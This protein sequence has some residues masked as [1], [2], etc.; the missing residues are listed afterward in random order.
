M[1]VGEFCDAIGVSNRSLNTFLGQSGKYKGSGSN[2]YDGAWEFFAKRDIAGIAMPS[3]KKLKTTTT[4]G[5]GKKSA[6]AA[7]GSSLPSIASIYLD[8]EDEDD[9]EV[10]D[11]CDEIRRKLNLHMKK[12]GVTQAQLC[13]DLHAQL[14]SLRAPANI[15]S[16]QL[17]SFRNKSGPVSGAKSSVY[18]TAYVFF[19]KL[20]IAEKKQKSQHR[21]G[22]EDEWPTGVNRTIDSSTT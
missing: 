2:A 5:G 21:L 4:D 9:V 3:K 17:T 22:M 15:T 8:G 20:R 14:H 10:Y 13:R 19:E 12:D 16:A 6:K 18:Y 11:T 1:K 7:A